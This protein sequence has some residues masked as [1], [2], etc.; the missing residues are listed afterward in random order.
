MR[1]ANLI[2]SS[3]SQQGEI[4]TIR[5]QLALPLSILKKL[6]NRMRSWVH[7]A[8]IRMTARIR[9]NAHQ[10]DLCHVLDGSHAYFVRGLEGLPVLTTCHDVIPLKQLNGDFGYERPGRFAGKLIRASVLGLEKSDFVI[11]DSNSTYDDLLQLVSVN[12]ENVSVVH[13]A[14]D[15][16]IVTN[17]QHEDII[18]TEPAVNAAIPFIFHIG[19]EAFYKNRQGVL[20]IFAKVQKQVKARLVLAGPEPSPTFRAQIEGL[21]ISGLVDFVIDPDDQL[22]SAYYRAA[23]LLLF[24]SIYEGFGW[25]PLEAMAHDCPVVCSDAASLPEVVGD[26]ALLAPAE[27]QDQLAKHCLAILQNPAL[28]KSMIRKGRQRLKHFTTDQMVDELIA[29]YSSVL[30]RQSEEEFK[31]RTS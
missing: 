3:L 28:A 25:P 5:L 16:R 15:D 29:I 11:A 8:W 21:G 7:H 23:S 19:N 27:N 26:A 18:K 6:P 13:I 22:I 24:P 14:M 17:G 4:S 20:R 9:I 1:Y 2:E 10:A 12:K 30:E 31:S